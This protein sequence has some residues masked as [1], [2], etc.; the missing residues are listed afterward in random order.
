MTEA[1][2]ISAEAI[3]R[4]TKKQCFQVDSVQSQVKVLPVRR[5]RGILGRNLKSKL[6]TKQSICPCLVSNM[7]KKFNSTK[8]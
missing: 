2:S 6:G 7:G 8:V 4:V 1:S 5:P 3:F